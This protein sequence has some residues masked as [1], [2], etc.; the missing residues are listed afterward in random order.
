VPPGD[1]I[2]ASRL[3]RLGSRPRRPL[4]PA[5][6][7]RTPYADNRPSEWL[8][9]RLDIP[10]IVLPYTVGGTPQATD[11]FGLFDDTLNRLDA[12]AP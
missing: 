4:Q 12:V 9:K 11:L 6:I 2:K 7:I 3:T 1:Q 10:A 8:A 5:A